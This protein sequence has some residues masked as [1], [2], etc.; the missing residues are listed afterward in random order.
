VIPVRR[1]P[2]VSDDRPGIVRA[3]PCERSPRVRAHTVN[4]KRLSRRELERGAAEYPEQP[5]RDYLRPRTFEECDSVGL[6]DITPCP[7]V[8][9]KRHLYLDVNPRTGSIKFNFPD[10]EVDEIPATC[11]LRVAEHGGRTLD[12]VAEVMGLTRQRLSQLEDRI[13]DKI[14]VTALDAAEDLDD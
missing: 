10:R 6:G 2:I 1:L 7:F 4:V 14:R 3:E 8:S 13:L 11:S 9:C 12:A 5:G